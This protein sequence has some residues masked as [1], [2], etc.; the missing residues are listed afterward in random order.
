[1]K[2]VL[3]IVFLLP[4]LIFANAC[5]KQGEK[6]DKQASDESF[7]V[8]ADRFADLRILRYRVHG[9]DQLDLE[10]KKLVYYLYQAALSGRDIIY[11]QHY[12]H[13]L[14]IRKT[15]EA[16]LNTY[17]GDR[18]SE[19]FDQ[20]LVYAKRVFFSNGIHHHY[21][22]KKFNPG[23]SEDYFK[24]LIS[25]TDPAAL[26]LENFDDVD[27]LV[28]F[29]TPILFD[30]AVDAK[31]VVKD[32]GVDL[33]ATSANNL[34][35]GVTQEEVEAFYKAMKDPNDATPP[36][37]G[38]NSKL[39]K[40]GGK[41]SEEVYKVGGLYSDAI[42][43][44]VF[45]LEKAS[46]VAEN[47]AQKKALDLLIKYYQTGDLR[48]F[49][50]YSIAWTQDTTSTVDVINGFIEVYGDP[51][52]MRGD[53]ESVVSIKDFEASKRMAAVAAN[54]QWFEDNSPIM[55]QHKRKN[56]AGVSYKVITVV[57]ESGDASPYTPVG[58]N[59]PNSNWIRANHG[60]KSVSLGNINE[61][62]NLAS[63]GKT[64]DEFYLS[65]ESKERRKE[66]GLIASKMHTALHEVIGH[67]SGKIEPGVGN[68]S[69]TLKN[70]RSSLEES[71]A[72]LVALYYIMD[73]K[74]VE[75]GLIPSTDVGKTEYDGY[76]KNGLQLQ[77][78]RLEPGDNIEQA[79]M[80]NR[81]MVS[82]WVYEKGLKD[83]VIEKV[84]IDGK[85]YVEINDYEKLRELFG[86]LLREVQRIKSQGDYEAGKNLIETYGVKVDQDMLREVHKRFEALDVAPYSGFINPK[87]VP[88]K[89]GETI[90]DVKVE[91]PE[92]FLQQM[93][94][95]GKEY[96]FLN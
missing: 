34:Y 3:R 89:D 90:T 69:E 36:M 87:L 39:V 41:I 30:P 20:F 82:S 5:T 61:A 45:W 65:E 91:Y 85:T 48:T 76:I 12:R 29:L 77:L 62:Y 47:D 46:E 2:S 40:E 59:L 80:R 25:G 19:D 35:E 23:F 31:K 17:G 68:P 74:L 56:A 27:A 11:D 81:Q 58:I 73:P 32:P 7:E 57:V 96:S 43:Q 18:D 53:Y 37:Y 10:K 4:F 79:H 84:V 93:L 64:T 66:Y 71:R 9:F 6:A 92:D 28:D 55:E 75:I 78:R 33:I 26:P 44:I 22:N 8:V 72:D 1:M 94:E 14:T 49:D 70:Y 63:G 16:I 52:G 60:S 67:A 42:E 83:N 86:Q 24:I 95:Y 54:A 50:E 38:L 15:L 51:L 21:A 88:V 13:N